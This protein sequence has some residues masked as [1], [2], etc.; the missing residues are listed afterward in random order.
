MGEN[1]S[2]AMAWSDG[3]NPVQPR[4]LS[5]SET[6]CGKSGIG[7]C[8]PDE[9]NQR[10]EKKE[11]QD[12]R[13]D[14]RGPA[15]VQSVSVL[16]VIGP[17]LGALRRQMRLRRRLVHEQT[18]FKNSTAGLLMSVGVEYERRRL[19]GK[20]YFD[21]LLKDNEWIDRELRPLLEF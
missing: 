20:R 13:A 19:H 16:F 6:L 2:G 8:G 3:I 17:E 21:S 12:R 5:T 7:A 4:D 10:G 15:A 9:G 1:D 11:R 14:H 18:S